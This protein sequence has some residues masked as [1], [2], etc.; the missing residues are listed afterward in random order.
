MRKESLMRVLAEYRLTAYAQY[1]GVSMPPPPPQNV[2]AQAQPAFSQQELDQ[3][4]APIALYPDPLL[5]QIL[6]ASTYPLEVVESARWSRANPNFSGDDAV[7]AIQQEPWDAS[8]KSLVAFPQ[9]LRMMDEKL[10]WTERLGDAFLAQEPQVMNT[11][12]NLRQKAYSAGNLA[13]SNYIQVAPEGQAIAVEPANPGIVYVPYYDPNVVYGQWWWPAYPPVYWEPWPGYFTGAGFAPVFSWDVGIVIAAGFFFGD[14]DWHH[15]HVHVVNV[16][17]Y[18]YNK[19]NHDSRNEGRKV[20]AAPGIWQHDPAHR[21]GVPYREEALYK[22]FGQASASHEARRSF[23]GYD[24]PPST[25]HA[26]NHGESGA[27]PNVQV[28]SGP[29]TAVS[30][31]AVEVRPHALENIERGADV[32]NHSSRGRE[33]FESAVQNQN[34]FPESRPPG[35]AIVEGKRRSK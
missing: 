4:L 24:H 33:S 27:P 28:H 19:I 25:N 6:M 8:V 26:T 31:P 13:S 12:Q 11:V 17:N 7:R 16:N 15:R 1:E 9:I 10:D 3:M 5:S 34:N 23:R 29:P 30:H 35:K 14:I 2:P 18:Y 22:Q 21:R 20:N 32:K